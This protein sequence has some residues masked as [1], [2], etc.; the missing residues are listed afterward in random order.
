MKLTQQQRREISEVLS[1]FGFNPKD[2]QV[3]LAL[4]E[5]GTTT[6]TPLSRKLG[7]PVTTVQSAMTRLESKGVVRT[8]KR[9]SRSVYE[10]HEPSVFKDLLR[11][12]ATAIASIVPLLQSLKT[13][14]ATSATIR[15]FERDR[16]TEILNESLKCKNKLVLEIVSAKPFQELIGEKYHYTKRRLM[17]QISLKSLR[18]RSTEMKKYNES[19]HRQEQREARFLP[20]EFTFSSTILLWDQTIAILST[21]PEGSHVMITSPSIAQM[22]RQLFDLLWSVSGKMETLPKNV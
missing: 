9:K 11:E 14:S 16:V 6:L 21:K 18:V 1:G 2:E 20:P 5:L 8:T 7:I 12:Q 13:T 22:Y 17:E 3:Y 19:I 15:V 4:L 10:A